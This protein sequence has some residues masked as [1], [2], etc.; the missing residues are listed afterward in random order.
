M[1]KSFHPVNFR[2]QDYFSFWPKVAG[3]LLLLKSSEHLYL[4][5]QV[6]NFIKKRLQH[7]CFPVNFA[8]F[9]NIFLM[10]HLR[11]LLLFFL[12][13]FLILILFNVLRLLAEVIW[14]YLLIR[15]FKKYLHSKLSIFERSAPALFAFI[16]SFKLPLSRVSI[17]QSLHRLLP[18]HD[19]NASNYQ[20]HCSMF[21]TL[22]I[23]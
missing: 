13:Q 2:K 1:I 19:L 9:K 18:N 12:A 17:K 11:W 20:E 5:L 22:Y 3:L 15:P 14:T 10:E 7:K 23:D 6:C 16:R 8:I 4:N 21:T